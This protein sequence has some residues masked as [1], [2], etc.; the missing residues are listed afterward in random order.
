NSG[1]VQFRSEPAHPMACRPGLTP[2]ESNHRQIPKHP[3]RKPDTGTV[4][5]WSPFRALAQTRIWRRRNTGL[6]WRWLGVEQHFAGRQ[7]ERNPDLRG[8]EFHMPIAEE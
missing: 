8:A 4:P 1:P 2:F 7:T 3:N 5:G 6:S